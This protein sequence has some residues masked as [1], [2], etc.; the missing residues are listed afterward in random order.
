LSGHSIGEESFLDYV[1][2]ELQASGVDPRRI[3]FEITETAAVGNLARATRF[4]AALHALGCC[5]ILD[6]FGSGFSSFAYLKN[7]K[8]DYLKIDGEFG[9]ALT[10]SGA[11]RAL[12][13]AIHQ[14]G[15]VMGIR[16]IAECVETP[17]ALEMVRQ[18][19][20]D[21]AQGF[22]IARPEPL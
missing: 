19:A 1:L 12:V 6:D 14:V 13:E 21:Y 8:V 4:M 18:I 5:F 7:L 10:P 20:V 22:G 11:Q 9:R 16:T 3:C 17:E 2:Q 15:H